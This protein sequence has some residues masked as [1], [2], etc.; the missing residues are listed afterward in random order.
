M[1]KDIDGL[2]LPP[3]VTLNVLRSPMDKARETPLLQLTVSPD[4]GFYEGG[5][6]RF[7]LE[8]NENYPIEPPTARCLSKIFHPNIDTRGKIC[9][10]ILREDWSPALDLQSIIIG[11]VFLFSEVSGKDPLNKEAANVLNQDPKKF[12]YLVKRSMAG[13]SIDNEHYDFVL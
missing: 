13:N 5:H 3:I 2:E 6:F 7:E 11:I 8:F 9:L 12:A 10:N 4:E 1:Q